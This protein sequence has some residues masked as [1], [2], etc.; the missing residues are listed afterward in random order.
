MKEPEFVRLLKRY[1]Q[2]HPRTKAFKIHGNQY[3][4]SGIPDLLIC[5][6]GRFIGVECKV[7]KPV[8]LGS[9]IR[10]DTAISKV[11]IYRLKEIIGA[12]GVGKICV[13]IHGTDK[14]LW[15]KVDEVKAYLYH[16][17]LEKWDNDNKFHGTFPHSLKKVRMAK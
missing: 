6:N 12:G 15:Y 17:L 16:D 13:F 11:Q 4:E 1:Y 7:V 10:L 8:K 9:I 14:I 2:K 5:S 3:Q